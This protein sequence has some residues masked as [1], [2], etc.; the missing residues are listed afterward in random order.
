MYVR[1]PRP[2]HPPRSH[3]TGASYGRALPTRL[4]RPSALCLR[5]L[6]STAGGTPHTSRYTAVL[7]VS[8]TGSLVGRYTLA[9]QSVPPFAINYRVV[10]VARGPN[11][12]SPGR[13]DG[14]VGYR[15]APGDH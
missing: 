8:V 7:R 5:R 2:R 9:D 10:P 12:A 3:L 14:Q 11:R 1:E 13:Q 6:R 15:C 4:A